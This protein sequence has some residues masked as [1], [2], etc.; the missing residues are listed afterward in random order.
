[1]KYLISRY[2]YLFISSKNKHLVYCSRS[3]AFFEVNSSLYQF[4]Q[5]CQRDPTLLQT[6]NQEMFNFLI[7]R[8]IVVK[9]KD[10]DDLLL[11]LE[12]KTNQSTYRK[13]HLGIVLVP[14]LGCNFACPYC[15]EP[16][17]KAVTMNDKTIDDLILF[18]KDHSDAKAFDLLWYGGEPLLAL[19]VIKKVLSKIH[20]VQDIKLSRHQ[21]VTNGYYFDAEVVDFFKENPLDT[22]QITL[23][24][25]RERHN[26]L[27]K[28]R[29][30]GEGSYDR[31]IENI[32]RIICELPE[33]QVYIRVNIDKNNVDDFYS[34]YKLLGERWKG[35]NIIIYP[36]ILRIDNDNKTALTCPSI[37][38]WET[39]ELFFHL[40]KEHM[41]D[42][43]I[44][45][46]FFY[47]KICS[48]TK[49]NSYIIGPEGEI[50]KCWNDVSDPQKIIGYINQEKLVNGALFYRYIVGSKW[51]NN[52]KCKQCFFLPIC[53]G[54][55]AW[56][57]L[58]NMYEGGEY[59][60]CDCLQKGTGMLN[61]C[62]EYQ[63]DSQSK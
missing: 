6:L 28:Q 3:N 50:Y 29:I 41:L 17:K 55:C 25:N 19:N 62:L 38:K 8:K 26:Q 49:V 12:F 24:G 46:R 13:T 57:R 30:T 14:T 23:D 37:Q 9:E 63:Y 53:N 21:I 61:K 51:Y 60:L 40:N 59:Y 43:P 36:G 39:A 54:Y 4:I 27:R 31:I 52:E 5:N 22:I 16:G 47:S 15:F 7:E 45:P 34:A 32:D 58:R 48:A 11:E 44:Y 20:T 18:I 33:T 10:D 42:L 2:V 1:M 35:K 56:Y